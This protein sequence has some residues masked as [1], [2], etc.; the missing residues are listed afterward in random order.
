MSYNPVVKAKQ[1]LNP[2]WEQAWLKGYIWDPE[3]GSAIGLML[4]VGRELFIVLKKGK[5]LTIHES[6]MTSNTN[7]GRQARKL[8]QEAGLIPGMPEIVSPSDYTWYCDACGKRG[9]VDAGLAGEVD[10]KG[11]G[12]KELA[13][14]IYDEHGVASLGCDPANVVVLNPQMVKEKELMRLISLERV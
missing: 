5:G 11:A 7:F 4:C 14:R 10:S 8:L 3:S 12:A 13:K 1:V 6:R 2:L 9:E